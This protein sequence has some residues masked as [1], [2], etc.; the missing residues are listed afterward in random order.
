M[1]VL[2]FPQEVS[3]ERD[4][5][6]ECTKEQL[7][8][9]SGLEARLDEVR[10]ADHPAVADLRQRMALL[11]EDLE[12]KRTELT[13]KGREVSKRCRGDSYKEYDMRVGVTAVVKSVVDM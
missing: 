9:I 11:Q 13:K 6:Q 10:R 2:F 4:T 3:A 1:A 5:L 12:A 7:V 8:K